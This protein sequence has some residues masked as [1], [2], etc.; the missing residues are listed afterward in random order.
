VTDLHGPA[1][2]GTLRAHAVRVLLDNWRGHSTVPSAGLYPHQ[3]SWDSAF[4]ACGL[5]HCA[6]RRAQSE[7]HSLFGGQWADGRVPHIVF[8]PGVPQDAYFPGPDVWCARRAG[9]GTPVETS[10]IVQP[11]VHAVAVL[12]VLRNARDPEAARAFAR[13]MY[14]RLV[15]QDDYLRASRVVD[16][17]GLA[18]IVHP[19]ESGMD[20]SPAWDE[21]LHAVPADLD[22]LK[23]YRRQDLRHA[24][25]EE[26]PTDHDYARYIRLVLDYRDRG[27]D[28]H[29]Y[30]AG[31]LFSV[32]DPLFNALWAWSEEA[33]AEIALA[34]GA[35]P[36]PHARRAAALTEA[37]C[38]RLFQPGLGMFAPYDVRRQ[39]TVPV[40]TV[41]GLVPLVLRGLPAEVAEALVATAT[42]EHFGVGRAGVLGVPSYD[43]RGPHWDPRRYWRGPTWL[44]TTWL[45]RHGLRVHGRD[46]LADRLTRDMLTML[47]HAG[48]REYFDPTTGDGLGAVNFS[49]SAA[50][51][52]D[53]MAGV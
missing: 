30:L 10:G 34:I 8:Q 40:R 19:W 3:W 39:Q 17:L 32:V 52:I 28:D 47:G 49:W 6:Q 31:S 15:A 44:N 51:A 46:D 42:S 20:N 33:L 25:A 16:G 7:L 14:P 22:L 12:S 9:S 41:G 43:L 29:R 35:E 23:V 1:D 2:T 50:L 24:T 48:Y 36:E 18:A 45:L 26:R 4:I 11:P 13:R 21:S 38:S 5:S 37:L 27:Y 53:T